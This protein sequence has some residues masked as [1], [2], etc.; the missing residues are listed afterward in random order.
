MIHVDAIGCIVVSSN[1]IVGVTSKP[2]GGMELLLK[3]TVTL[4]AKIPQ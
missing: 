4:V 1:V 3:E 2:F